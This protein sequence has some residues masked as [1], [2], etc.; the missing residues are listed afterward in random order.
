MWLKNVSGNILKKTVVN[1]AAKGVGKSVKE[2]TFGGVPLSRLSE[3]ARQC[4]RGLGCSID[5]WGYLLFHYKSNRGHQ[6]YRVQMKID[7]AGKLVN[8]GG[9]YPGQSRSTADVFADMVNTT[10]ELYK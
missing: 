8:L 9:H 3:L 5:E 6:R 2:P 10:F 1:N 7:D 4:Y